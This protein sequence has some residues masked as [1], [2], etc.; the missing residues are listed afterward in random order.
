MTGLT[1]IELALAKP[2]TA[3]KGAGGDC[4]DEVYVSCEQVYGLG[5]LRVFVQHHEK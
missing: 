1:G 4:D 3:D 5:P 2:L